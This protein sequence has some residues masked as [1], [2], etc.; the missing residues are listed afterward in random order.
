MASTLIILILVVPLAAA[1][2]VWALGAANLSA[3]RSLTLAAVLIN[4]AITLVAVVPASHDLTA[5]STLPAGM[6]FHPIYETNALILPFGSSDGRAGIRFHIGLD[7]INIWLVLLT[8]FLMVPSV[9]VGWNVIQERGNE[10]YAWLLVLQAAMTGVFLAFDIILFYI[11]FELTLVP[12][13]FLIGIWG[14]PMR[15]EAS[16]KFFL[17]TL[18][19][20]LIT[21]LGM[22]AI[23]LVCYRSGGKAELTFSIPELVTQVGSLIASG[24]PV[25]TTKLQV[26]IFLALAVGFAVKVPLFPVH[27]WLPLAHVEAPT[28]GSVLLAG[29][30]L[31]L[32]TYGFL[33]LCLPLVPDGV[34][35]VGVPLLGSLAAIGIVYGA[36]CAYAQNDVKKLVA[37]SSVSHLGFCV[38]GLVALNL[39]GLTGSLLQ[40]VNHG[41]S[42][43]GL[44]LLVGMLYERYHTRMMSDYSGLA[45][46]LKLLSAFMVFICL[47]SV[48][49]PGLNGFVGEML[50]LAGTYSMPGATFAGVPWYSWSVA[51]GIVLGG[52]YLFTMLKRVFFG[53]LH[54]P[55]HDGHEVSDLTGR[56]LATLLPVMAA[57][58]AL[59]LWPQ[60]V[61]DTAKGDL[62]VVE[63]IVGAAKERAA[64][65][66]EKP[67]VALK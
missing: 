11:F 56:E 15:R 47:T 1:V 37:Y 3:V 8:S 24:R 59:G 22:M 39:A 26:A 25:F 42:T 32:G 31:K 66:S 35:T 48:G 17:Y 20:S 63:K 9:L 6:T 43:G 61:I 41:L 30:L 29:V 4:L 23:V 7:G 2:A 49:M 21:L 13:Y 46:R 65:A 67:A 10:Y 36:M 51:A 64:R 18:A 19:G 14:G 40:M 55:H 12:L 33:R 16:R 28:A 44:F 45:A 27:T 57:C 34:A 53:P 5:R 54:E 38:L 52:W 58:L 60:P 50:V 62:A